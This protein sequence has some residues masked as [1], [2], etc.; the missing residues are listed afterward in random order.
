MVARLS[1]GPASVN[2]LAEPFDMTLQA[3]S[4]HLKVLE[5]AG[6]VTRERAAQSRPARFAGPA[7]AEAS[8]W[9][10]DYRE[11]FTQSFERLDQLV[12]DDH[13]TQP[14]PTERNEP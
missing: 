14:T 12:G 7:L 2:E 11:F 3:V 5:R 13:H 9:L 1:R 6:I 8:R 4:K 10:S